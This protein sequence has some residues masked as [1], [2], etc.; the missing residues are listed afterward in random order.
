MG[1][2][3]LNC[4]DVASLG[5]IATGTAKDVWD[6]VKNEWGKSTDMRHSHA[7]DA[8]N[9]TRYVEGTNI[10]DHIKTL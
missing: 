4:T 3:T 1:H 7:Q 2:I 5:V 9:Q 8:L 6:S 10:Q